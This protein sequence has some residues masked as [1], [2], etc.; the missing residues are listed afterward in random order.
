M[1]LNKLICIPERRQEY[2][3]IGQS[4]IA[5]LCTS[6]RPAIYWTY[7][8]YSRYMMGLLL[9][10]ATGMGLGGMFFGIY[11]GTV[12]VA[13]AAPTGVTTGSTLV[14]ELCH[15]VF[16]NMAYVMLYNVTNKL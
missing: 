9:D 15:H 10:V 14:L 6:W 7:T 1:V 2:F 3:S 13:L 11:V 5:S 16:I 12:V 4:R 8:H